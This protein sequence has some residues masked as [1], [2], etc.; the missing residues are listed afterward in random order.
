MAD[1]V[2]LRFTKWDGREHWVAPLGR[3][4]SDDHGVWLGGA[5]G[6]VFTRPGVVAYEATGPLV[7]LVPD[8][9]PWVATFYGDGHRHD[10]RV[11]VDMTTPAVWSAGGDDVTMVDLDLDVVRRLDGSVYVDDEDEFAAHQV[12][13]SYPPEIVRL[14]ERSRDEALA[15]VRDQRAPFAPAVWEPW[16]GQ[17]S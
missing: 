5:A 17:V 8:G 2:L 1:E 4:G 3:L 16:L 14:A 12:E 10:S 15:A 13:L 7:M 11:Y 9:R 6:T